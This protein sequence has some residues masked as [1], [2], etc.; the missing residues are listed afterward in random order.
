[1]ADGGEG[2]RGEKD[3]TEGKAQ[4][5]GWVLASLLRGEAPDLLARFVAELPLEEPAHEQLESDL[6]SWC[7]VSPEPALDGKVEPQ[8][9]LSG[10]PPPLPRKEEA[11]LQQ[12]RR[13]LAE[14]DVIMARLAHRNAERQAPRVEGPAKCCAGRAQPMATGLV[15]PMQPGHCAR[16]VT[17]WRSLVAPLAPSPQARETS[18][19]Y[20]ASPAAP[21]REGHSAQLNR[22][23]TVG[24]QINDFIKARLGASG[25]QSA[26]KPAAPARIV[27]ELVPSPAAPS[28]PASAARSTSPCPVRPE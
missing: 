19:R 14:L 12:L 17:A 20:S 16:Q 8:M 10:K 1:M 15:V 25:C 26:R 28:V 11:P 6:R 18:R 4:L 24:R 27:T 23:D 2:V 9:S 5:S 3:D 7:L 21:L 22:E 13:N